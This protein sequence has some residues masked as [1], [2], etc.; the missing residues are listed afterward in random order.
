MNVKNNLQRVI[1]LK[2]SN[3]IAMRACRTRSESFRG[4]PEIKR[5][6]RGAGEIRRQ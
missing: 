2:L 1:V 5:G 6:F 3:D 4:E